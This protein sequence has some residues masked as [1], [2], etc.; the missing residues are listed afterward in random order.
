MMIVAEGVET[1][2]EYHTLQDMGIHL[3]QGY[4]FARPSFESLPDINWG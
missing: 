4:Y 1:K 2:A 3:F